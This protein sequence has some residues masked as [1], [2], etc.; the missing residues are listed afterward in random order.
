MPPPV[1][2]AVYGIV[3][4]LEEPLTA[5]SNLLAG[6]FEGAD[7]ASRRFLI[8]TFLGY[9]GAEDVAALYYGFDRRPADLRKVLCSIG[10][11]AGPIVVVPLFGETNL[12]DL[13]GR[14]GTIFMLYHVLGTNY[15]PYRV[16]TGIV[17][18]IDRGPE[19]EDTSLD[20]ET[21]EQMR[22][23]MRTAADQHC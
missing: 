7:V 16:S 5:V 12:R 14:Y 15:V 6:D 2:N 17:A 18:T 10:L 3:T 11:P 21:F 8:N 13:F 22:A 1:R 20:G 9:A 23:R 19:G 4:N